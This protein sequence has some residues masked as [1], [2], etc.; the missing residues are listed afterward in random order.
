[1]PHREEVVSIENARAAE[2]RYEWLKAADIYDQNISSSSREENSRL[3]EFKERMAYC[4]VQ[5]AFQAEQLRVFD[6]RL[7]LAAESYESCANFIESTNDLDFQDPVKIYAR[8]KYLR[9]N[10]IRIRGWL[11]DDVKLKKE[12]FEHAISLLEE[13]RELKREVVTLNETLEHC[14]LLLSC[15]EELNYL[16][17]DTDTYRRLVQK[18][19]TTSENALGRASAFPKILSRENKKALCKTYA[20]SNRFY[21]AA[22][23]ILESESERVK[24][25]LLS[26]ESKQAALSLLADL[27]DDALSAEC[28]IY[29]FDGVTAILC[30][31]CSGG[32]RSR[33]RG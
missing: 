13:A 26:E 9:S 11:C 2:E 4:Y 25:Q 30:G 14:N 7:I 20:F 33:L 23:E 19:V 32:C 12:A 17:T 28:Y 27:D 6:L 18:A 24:Y 29:L 10:A 8:A 22:S 21:S 5:S 31:T 3:D 15:Y 16:T 1:M